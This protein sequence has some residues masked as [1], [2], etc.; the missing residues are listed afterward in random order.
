MR[1][2][3]LS[4]VMP[5]LSTPI[6]P[7]HSTMTPTAPAT[8]MNLFDHERT[9][10]RE[11][12]ALLEYRATTE[13]NMKSTYD[14]L[15]NNAEKD[16]AR[17]KRQLTTNRDREIM[18]FNEAQQQAL[19][20]IE[21]RYHNETTLIERE[22][23][24][25][26]DSTTR[27]NDDA[28]QKA[29]TG[30]QDARWTAESIYE[31]TEKQAA[32]DRTD[33]QRKAAAIRERCE[34]LWTEA[35]VPLSRAALTRADLQHDQPH[36][37]IVDPNRTVEEQFVRAEEAI[38]GLVNS[39]G[40]K[41][42]TVR[43][44]FLLLIPFGFLTAVPTLFIDSTIMALATGGAIG[45]ALTL[46]THFIIKRLAYKHAEGLA[47]SFAD[48]LAQIETACETMTRRADVDYQRRVVEGARLREDGKKKADDTFRPLIEQ[49]VARRKAEL[50]EASEKYTRGKERT[51]KWR[52]ESTEKANAH[53]TH[54]KQATE[55][56]TVEE[57]LAADQLCQDIT[58]KAKRERAETE[59]ALLLA[60]SDGQE[61]IGSAINKLR[62]NGLEHYPDW[63]SPFWYNPPAAVKVPAGVRFGDF[64]VNL[65][66]LPGGVP[67][68]SDGLPDTTLPMR[69][70]LPAFLP[71][72]DRCSLLLKARDQGRQRAVQA[73]QAIML[74]LLT[75]IPPGKLRFT[76]IDPVGLGEN[77]ASFMH[78]TDYDE[79]LVGARIW[80]EPQQIEKR[81]ADVT[82]H[83]ETVIQK[84]LR[85]QYKTIEEYNAFA[86]EVAE[87]F[88]VL[89]VANFPANFTLD[90]CRRLVSIINSGPS[91]GV[92]T[93][94]TYD[95]KQPIPQGFN[96]ADVEQG[97]INLVW[98]D[99]AFVWKEPDFAK[100]P[101]TLETPPPLEE[102]TRLVRLVGERSKDANRVE[103]PFEYVGPKAIEVWASDSRGGVSVAIGRAGATKRQQ[104]A[105]GKGT[106]QHAL[107]A[108]KTGS[109]KS[110]LLHALITNLAMNYSPDE[111]ELYLIDFKKGVEFK[112]Y[113]T[114]R[115]PHAKAVAIESEREFG[116]SVL[117]RLDQELKVRGD[118]FRD[119]GVNSVAEYRAYL[120]EANKSLPIDAHRTCPRIMLI[121]DE[122]QE[123]FIEEDRVAQECAML[124]DR[125]VRQGRAFGLHVVLGSQTLGGAYSLARSTIDQMAVRIALQC[126]D[127]DAQLIL[128]KDN[129]A[130]RLLSRPG[131]AIYNDANGLM[132]GN[133][134]FQVVWLDDDHRE[135]YLAD[136]R[137]RANQS[138]RQFG[139]PL[140]FEGNIPA[141]VEKNLPLAQALA[142]P[143]WLEHVRT[144]WAWLGDAVAIKDPTAIVFRANGG[145]NLL[146]VGQHDE[147]ALAITSTMLVSLTAQLKPTAAKFFILDGTPED[148]PHAGLL[149][150]VANVLPHDIRFLDRVNMGDAFNAMATEVA[151]RQKGESTDRSPVYFF[152]HGVQRF[153]DLRKEDDFG[154]GR[155]G[156]E[157]V[158]SPG[159][160]LATLLRDGPTVGVH[161]ILWADTP[162]NLGRSVDRA[163]MREFALR[164]L[165][166]MSANDSSSLIDSPAASR[167]GRNRALFLTEESAQPEKFRPYGLPTAEWL[168]QVKTAMT[169]KQQNPSA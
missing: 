107:I 111:L 166:Q 45:L 155:R 78:L 4:G 132:E 116:L 169:A 124:L 29:R 144:P 42:A 134:L 11:L 99:D 117:Q 57:L 10:L 46:I 133:D 19:D 79:Q 154:F 127:A 49:I 74:R 130:A 38:V 54:M 160:H 65:E 39:R 22:Y 168:Q 131:E 20:E 28:E 55:Q 123:F 120:D 21:T 18:G 43:G 67:I 157:R 30:Y 95:P 152:I 98:K 91:C 48:A 1:E 165:F 34:Q 135:K 66:T 129:N 36:D 114:H 23:Q 146:M 128:S 137:K 97:S 25:R 92:Y 61:R 59:R 86:G 31:A 158:V 156:A 73:I 145:Q 72:P 164:I 52:T 147:G 94:V 103:V 151:A 88:R 126:S 50:T 7:S 40:L 33:A 149:Q 12:V 47:L 119:A 71:F 93:L 141:I 143:G 62:A 2:H 138:P 106:A 76:I 104:F 83:M 60:W 15:V 26:K 163:G 140:V 44:F 56:R 53:Y 5:E 27:E 84:Y 118:Q 167:L 89:V 122:F 41:L 3:D 64:E 136:V 80:T 153:R 139:A 77:F 110:T 112:A 17:T 161:L 90:A 37:L 85:N 16:L 121:V 159:E 75:A 69:L 8:R 58:T 6:R 24:N 87:P 148:D 101:L 68:G 115:L 51:A 35:T 142:F 108:G 125:L 109:G 102:A 105:L 63:D 32:D 96:L 150:R 82:A 13:A 113:A 70:K 9:A 100:F 81:L 14:S 162:T